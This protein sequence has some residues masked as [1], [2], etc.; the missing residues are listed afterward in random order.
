MLLRDTLFA[1]ERWDS[2]LLAPPL[3]AGPLLGRGV[4]WERIGRRLWPGLAGVHIVEATKSL[5][6]VSPPIPVKQS[7]RTLA[8]ASG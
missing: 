4:S 2:A 6:A 7:E 3:R 8:S 5:Y 1:P